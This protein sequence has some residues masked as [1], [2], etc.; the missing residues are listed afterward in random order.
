MTKGIIA[1]IIF[2]VILLAGVVSLFFGKGVKIE[3]HSHTHQH[4]E[5]FQGQLM[6]NFI[7]HRG[8]KVE[9]KRKKLNSLEEILSFLATLP[10]QESYFAKFVHPG[11]DVIY[12]T[13]FKEKKEK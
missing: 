11:H 5:Q 8:D 4:Q 6:M 2:N 7:M 1:S 12:P 9:W 10:P 3:K 13:F